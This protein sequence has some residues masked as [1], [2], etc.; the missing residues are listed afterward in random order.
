MQFP[1]D[2]PL[3]IIGKNSGS[4]S[5][6]MIH[7]VKKHFH[8]TS[9]DDCVISVSKNNNYV[10]ISVVIKAHDQATL[11]ALY[12]ELTQHPDTNMVL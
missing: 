3:K 5:N 6:E 12:H 4:F 2:F 7:I 8:L 11:D 10:S 9:A 1:C